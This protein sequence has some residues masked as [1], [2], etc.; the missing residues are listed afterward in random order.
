[1]IGRSLSMEQTI[2]MQSGRRNHPCHQG[3]LVVCRCRE[4][5]KNGQGIDHLTGSFYQHYDLEVSYTEIN[6][7]LTR[8][9]QHKSAQ[10]K[11]TLQRLSLRFFDPFQ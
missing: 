8:S 1:V 3:I 5:G 4:H 10:P 6:M 11:H 7:L 2:L 9:V